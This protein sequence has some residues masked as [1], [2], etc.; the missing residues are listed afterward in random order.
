VPDAE[1]PSAHQV[2][3]LSGRC[4]LIAS[5]AKRTSDHPSGCRWCHDPRPATRQGHSSQPH[6]RYQRQPLQPTRLLPHCVPLPCPCWLPYGFSSTLAI[7][8]RTSAITARACGEVSVVSRL[9]SQAIG[10]NKLPCER[11]GERTCVVEPA[12]GA[13]EVDRAAE[14]D[15]RQIC[16]WDLD[17][18]GRAQCRSFSRRRCM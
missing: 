11:E 14:R 7:T 15:P 10:F 9:E 18:R 16:L 3:R 1:R 17:E 13:L 5:S 2:N 8:L 12:L 6:W 4:P